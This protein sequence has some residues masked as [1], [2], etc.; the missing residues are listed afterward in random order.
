MEMEIENSIAMYVPK[1][2]VSIL[3][4]QTNQE[5]T[6]ILRIVT[7]VQWRTNNRIP[8]QQI[9]RKLNDYVIKSFCVIHSSLVSIR[10]SSLT[11]NYKLMHVY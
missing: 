10:L 4:Y 7:F 3:Y 1:F 5:Q 9:N 8:L 2:K 6:K 11:L